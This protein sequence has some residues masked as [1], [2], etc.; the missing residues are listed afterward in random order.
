MALINLTPERFVH[1][2]LLGLY[3]RHWPPKQYTSS[4][5]NDYRKIGFTTVDHVMKILVSLSFLSP[6]QV[7]MVGNKR[8]GLLHQR[9]LYHYCAYYHG[10][11][12]LSNKWSLI[13][14]QGRDLGKNCGLQRLV[15]N[16]RL[17]I[18]PAG[19]E[20]ARL[21]EN[22]FATTYGLTKDTY[23]SECE[24]IDAMFKTEVAS[25]TASSRYR[26]GVEESLAEE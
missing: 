25:A 14:I 4:I 11:T 24:R 15:R 18:L 9:K 10:Q 1:C 13:I 23:I 20:V 16:Q 6:D 22:H 17:E 8:Q 3:W 12:I 19:V 5:G 7:A 26:R 2:I 21:Q